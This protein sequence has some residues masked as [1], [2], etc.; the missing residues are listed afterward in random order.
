MEID[1]ECCG[2]QT[3]QN[4]RVIL[5]I[6]TALVQR[7]TQPHQIFSLHYKS[8]KKRQ[9]HYKLYVCNVLL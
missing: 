8:K 2:L 4:K 9:Y 3:E 1:Y 6:H 5:K 7:N